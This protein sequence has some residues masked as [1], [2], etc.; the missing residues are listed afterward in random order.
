M[1]VPEK[2]RS[3][4]LANSNLYRGETVEVERV[5]GGHNRTGVFDSIEVPRLAED[6]FHHRVYEIVARI[7]AGCVATYGQIAELA[8]NPRGARMVGWAMHSSPRELHLP[9]HRVVNA[10]GRLAPGRVFGGAEVQRA[11]LEAEGVTFLAGDRIDMRR[12]TWK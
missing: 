3:R 6:T 7:P 11:M 10:A 5:P 8:G 9:C 12:H 4:S 2:V 1:D